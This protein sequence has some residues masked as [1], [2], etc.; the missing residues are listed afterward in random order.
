MQWKE[1][2]I[3]CRKS[4]FLVALRKFD[5]KIGDQGMNVIITLNL[6]AEC[7]SKFQFFSLDCINIHFLFWGERK[8]DLHGDICDPKGRVKWYI[9]AFYLTISKKD[10]WQISNTVR[11]QRNI[12]IHQIL[13]K[14]SS[15]LTKL[16]E[17]GKRGH[18]QKSVSSWVWQEGGC[19]SWRKSR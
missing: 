13:S 11:N 9:Q 10:N 19:G 5:I 16:T 4:H 2:Q 12:W 1:I 18:S 15:Y 7:W 17:C 3:T 6:E 14:W 8:R